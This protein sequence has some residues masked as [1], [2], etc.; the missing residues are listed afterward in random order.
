MVRPYVH[1]GAGGLEVVDHL[2]ELVLTSSRSARRHTG[3]VAR[4]TDVMHSRLCMYVCSRYE[5]GGPLVARQAEVRLYMYVCAGT[6]SDVAG[7][8]VLALEDRV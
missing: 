1:G 6:R 2:G 3:E 8:V 5:V 7:A 4:G